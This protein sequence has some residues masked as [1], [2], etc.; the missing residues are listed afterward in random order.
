MDA[1]E[2]LIVAFAH[3]P[4]NFE[5]RYE[6]DIGHAHLLGDNPWVDYSGDMPSLHDK[7]A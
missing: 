3:G 4:D 5:I 2:E 7:L 1:R 6:A